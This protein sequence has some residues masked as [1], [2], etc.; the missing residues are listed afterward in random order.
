MNRKP[1]Q[2][3]KVRDLDG[4]ERFKD[5]HP[6]LMTCPSL[7]VIVGAIKSSKSNLVINLF[8][9]NDFYWDKKNNKSIFDTVRVLSTTLHMDNKMKIMNE[10]FDCDDHYQDSY[11]DD[12]IKSQGQFEKDDPN[13]PKYALVMDDILTPEFMKRTNKL[14]FFCTKM[15]HYIDLMVIS[16]Q[17]MNHVPS[18]IRA[19]IRDLLIGKQQNHKEV[20]KLQEQFGGLLGENGDKKF[21]ELYNQVHKNQKYQFMYMKLSE[22]PVQVFHNF[23]K[24]IF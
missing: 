1:P 23:D 13:R 17:S 2:I 5:I 24:Q 21:L 19:Q 6:N 3:L 14:C 10:H 16:T 9:N 8:C 12:I 4:D 22:N 7:T 11:I 20:I 15:R 18:L